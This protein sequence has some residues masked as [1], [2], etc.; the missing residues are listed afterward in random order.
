M[1]G[2]RHAP[3]VLPPV[4]PGTHCIWG[5]LGHRCHG[6]GKS[7][8]LRNS[9]SGLSSSYLPF[10]PSVSNIGCV[11]FYLMIQTAVN[12]ETCFWV[13]KIWREMYNVFLSVSVCVL[14][15]DGREETNTCIYN[16]LMTFYM[17]FC[18]KWSRRILPRC[19]RMLRMLANIAFGTLTR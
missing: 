9:I 4:L 10:R 2:Q 13:L 11:V 3:A 12:S 1:G 15:R 17:L 16:Y 5:W 18:I 7:R 6:C 19:I 14:G 8:P